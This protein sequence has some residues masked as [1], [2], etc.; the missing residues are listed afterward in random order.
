MSIKILHVLGYSV[1]N[2]SGYTI[3][4][5]YLIESENGLGLKPAVITSSKYDHEKPFVSSVVLSGIEYFRTKSRMVSLKVPFL[6]ELFITRAFRREIKKI[7]VEKEI[8]VIHAHSPS[9]NG[10]AALGL[11]NNKCKV[12]LIYHVRALWEDAAVESGKMKANSLKYIISYYAENFLLKKADYI[13]VICEGLKT[14]LVNRGYNAEKIVI[15]ENGVDTASFQPIERSEKLT[16]KY[17]LDKTCVVGFIGSLFR[18][19]GVCDLVKAFKLVS[20][21][22]L[23]VKLMIIG[24]GEEL[25]YIKELSREACIEKDI[26][27]TGEIPHNEVM[28]YYSIIDIVVYP[29]IST[30]LTE[31]VTPLKPLEAMS[32]G[33]AVI[34][35]DVGGIKELIR[36]EKTGLLYQS[37]DLNKL[38]DTI[39]RLVKDPELRLLL[40]RAGME[41]MRLNRNWSL[42]CKKMMS[43]YEGLVKNI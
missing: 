19:E 11:K 23:S 37:G 4:S 31:L 40:G 41:D 7:V 12:P 3:R 39:V 16:K 15:I 26:I 9:L 8:G 43:V 1:P 27:I 24:K 13:V 10:L 18:F 14:E 29:R 22:G 32:M 5:K 6:K 17:G 42:I 25:E 20:E 35:S 36:D 33:K 30:R 34:G 38:S 2:I 21:Q 28:D